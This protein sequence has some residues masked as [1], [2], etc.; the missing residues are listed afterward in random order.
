MSGARNVELLNLDG[1]GSVVGDVDVAVPA[2][3]VDLAVAGIDDVSGDFNVTAGDAGG[4]DENAAAAAGLP[5]D[6]EIGTRLVRQRGDLRV[7]AG[8]EVL[9]VGDRLRAER[10]VVVGLAALYEAVQIDG[11]R[12]DDDIIRIEAGCGLC[13][14]DFVDRL[15]GVRIAA[16][17]ICRGYDPARRRTAGAVGPDSG[18]LS[19]VHSCS[20]T[21]PVSST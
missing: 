17:V 20:G 13:R 15:A 12:L 5:I 7:A 10:Q 9:D 19:V 16:R 18:A 21:P 2:Q 14:E 4:G 8:D 11:R 1:V 3:H 6:F